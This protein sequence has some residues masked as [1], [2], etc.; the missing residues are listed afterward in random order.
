ML[1]V[2]YDH[3]RNKTDACGDGRIV[4]VQPEAVVVSRDWSMQVD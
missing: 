3:H 1:L 4:Q 2:D